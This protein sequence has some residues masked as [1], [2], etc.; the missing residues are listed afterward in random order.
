MVSFSKWVLSIAQE[1][2]VDHLNQKRGSLIKAEERY[3]SSHHRTLFKVQIDLAR[4]KVNHGR[5]SCQGTIYRACAGDSFSG[6]QIMSYATDPSVI[7]RSWACVDGHIR[8][9]AKAFGNK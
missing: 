8:L 4:R 6:L 3:L 2:L 1:S 7:E 9:H 5:W